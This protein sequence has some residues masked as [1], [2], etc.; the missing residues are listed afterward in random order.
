MNSKLV[1]RACALLAVFSVLACSNTAPVPSEEKRVDL[2]GYYGSPPKDEHEAIV[3]KKAL[4]EKQR[5]E[6]ERQAREIEDLKRQQHYNEKMRAYSKRTF[7]GGGESW[8]EG[9]S[10]EWTAD[11]ATQKPERQVIDPSD[12]RY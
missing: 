12:E 6:I 2:G 11:E 7:R 4:I 5:E 8:T 3:Q 10:E 9:E 1:L